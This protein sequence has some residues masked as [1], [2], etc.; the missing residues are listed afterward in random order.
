MF[1][2]KYQDYEIISNDAERRKK[3]KKSIRISPLHLV[4]KS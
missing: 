1:G 3:R 4:K 2:A